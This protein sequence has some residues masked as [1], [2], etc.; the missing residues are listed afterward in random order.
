MLRDKLRSLCL[1]QHSP[2]K[3]DQYNSIEREQEEEERFK[4]ILKKMS[5]DADFTGKE[6]KEPGALGRVA[7]CNFTPVSL[8]S[9]V[10]TRMLLPARALKEGVMKDSDLATILLLLHKCEWN[11]DEAEKLYKPNQASR[12]SLSGW[13]RLGP[14]NE[15]KIKCLRTTCPICYD[16]GNLTTFGLHC[17]HRYC[18]KCYRTYVGQ[19]LPKGNPIRCLNLDCSVEF[20]HMYVE[21]L[22]EWPI[23]QNK[24]NAPGSINKTADS[25]TPE[26]GSSLT[27]P[28]PEPLKTYDLS[29]EEEKYLDNRL[30]QSVAK[31]MVLEETGRYTWCPILNCEHAVEITDGTL[32][33]YS[34]SDKKPLSK[35]FRAPVVK[36]PS[37][38]EFCSFCRAENHLPCPCLFAHNIIGKFANDKRSATWIASNTTQCP[39]CKA[40]IEK[41]G[42]CDNM[43]CL[44]GRLFRWGSPSGPS[45][46]GDGKS[47]FL[48]NSQLPVKYQTVVD[49]IMENLKWWYR[50]SCDEL[51]PIKKDSVRVRLD[52][53][54]QAKSCLLD[55]SRQ[56]FWTEV[57]L[58][59]LVSA[60]A[61]SHRK[62]LRRMLKNMNLSMKML[63]Q[64]LKRF[65]KVLQNRSELTLPA[66][67][68]ALSRFDDQ[69][70]STLIASIKF[71]QEQI[72]RLTNRII[73]EAE[74]V[75]HLIELRQSSSLQWKI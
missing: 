3:S 57:I 51:G 37:Q 71:H 2:F 62:N 5:L 34:F 18:V 66:L 41:N 31:K 69:K 54:A 13:L 60:F 75:R 42:G 23:S 24:M 38:H 14:K 33:K 74:I 1:K 59:F 32:G 68:K 4:G 50:V 52:L 16:E 28:S 55:S 40:P 19:L 65:M 11:L 72:T 36:C 29:N 15:V 61:K 56:K 45:P 53:M 26:E 70:L 39:S 58:H 9:I 48:S 49:A 63:F 8:R 35:Y 30:L 21:T 47:P 25:E 20:H 73:R 7:T 46:E 44:C 22:L 12:L 17:G 27:F 6:N 43:T 67:E 10:L 64:L